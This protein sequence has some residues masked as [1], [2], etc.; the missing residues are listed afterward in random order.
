MPIPYKSLEEHLEEVNLLNKLKKSDEGGGLIKHFSNMTDPRVDRS[1]RHLLIDIIVIGICAVI[2]GADTWT[3]M[4]EYGRSKYEWLKGFLDLP[5]GIPSHDTF[6]RV[7]RLLGPKEFQESFLNWIKAVNK[8]TGGQVI[9]IDGKT[10]RHSFDKGE[11]KGAI[12]MV[13]AWATANSLVLGQVKVDDKSNEI[14]AIPELLKML[15][16][17][18]CIVTI[19]AM[20]CQKK[21]AGLIIDQGA[22]YV[23]ALKGNHGDLH[24]DVEFFFEDALKNG[25]GDFEYSFYEN[26]DGDHGRIETRRYWSVSDINWITQKEQWK[27]FT[28]ICM[29]ESERCIGDKKSI[30]RRH[31]ISSLDS[32]ATRLSHA[33]RGHWG[34]ENSLHWVLD[35]AFREDESRIRKGYSPQN[36]A[37]LRHIALNLLKQEKT[38]K[39]GIKSKRLKAGWDNNYL[40]KVLFG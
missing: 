31:Y 35:I 27:G 6:G 10:L 30:E 13:S 15:E 24:E 18:G 1:K 19:D 38:A 4:E 5:E 11:G 28:S 23:L 33:I 21:I 22:D 29:V 12:H 14:T 36:F 3:G 8:I 32:D 20:G 17:S 37:V 2:C 39:V 16:V 40:L 25:F 7:F 26:I 9:A 34:I